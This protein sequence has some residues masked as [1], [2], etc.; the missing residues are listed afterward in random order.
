MPLLSFDQINFRVWE[1]NDAWTDKKG[2]V[3]RG[4]TRHK[5]GQRWKEDQLNLMQ[6]FLL[7]S[8]LVPNIK[9][10]VH[11]LIGG[12]ETKVKTKVVIIR[13]PN[14]HYLALYVY[15]YSS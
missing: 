6:H 3:N 11:P 8:A 5:S 12:Q 2:I 7:M 4:V 15:L 9:E 14:Y 10:Y 1:N 13:I